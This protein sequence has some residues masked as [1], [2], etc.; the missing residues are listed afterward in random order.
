MAPVLRVY[1]VLI[2]IRLMLKTCI[3]RQTAITPDKKNIKPYLQL[4]RRYIIFKIQYTQNRSNNKCKLFLKIQ[5]MFCIIRYRGILFYLKLTS[6]GSKKCPCLLYIMH[7][8]YG[9]PKG[10]LLL[11]LQLV[12]P[13]TV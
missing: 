2:I 12:S 3:R 1:T 5:S 8:N 10:E 9:Y 6:T 7:Y 13:V 4:F 11:K